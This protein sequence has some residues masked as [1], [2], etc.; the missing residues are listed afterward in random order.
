[1]KGDFMSGEVLKLNAA[2]MPVDIIDW[3]EAVTLWSAN[4]AEIV[5]TYEDRL[6]HTG[7]RF[8]KPNFGSAERFMRATYDKNLESWKTAMEMPA[9]IRLFE[10]V[11]PKK[12]IKF[13]ESFT[14]HNVYERDGGKCVY[15]GEPVSRN[16][17]TFDHV[18]PKSRG[19]HT[20]WQNIVCCCLRCNS[21][22]DNRTPGEAG[23]K[24]RKRPFAPVIA[25]NFNS[26]VMNRLRGVSKI[27]NNKKWQDY[28]YWNVELTQD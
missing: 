5:S 24:L 9:V 19:G 27:L 16:K 26:G 3:E 10:F 21:K 7:N 12:Q 15:C 20:N 25:D 28:I 23:M 1:M 14:R 11:S 2:Y 13:F 18:I 4:K 22:K 8:T 6:L 17:F